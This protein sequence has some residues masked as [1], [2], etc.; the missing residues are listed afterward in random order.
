MTTRTLQA[1]SA[2][3]RRLAT[4]AIDAA[5]HSAREMA[6]FPCH[7]GFFTT[8]PAAARRPPPVASL[9]SIASDVRMRPMMAGGKRGTSEHVKGSRACFEADELQHI[10]LQGNNLDRDAARASS[11]TRKRRHEA[12]QNVSTCFS[13]AFGRVVFS[14]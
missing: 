1:P 9:G 12:K 8:E 10:R 14:V 3:Y 4:P 11:R 6:G 5:L 13:R 2:P 7:L